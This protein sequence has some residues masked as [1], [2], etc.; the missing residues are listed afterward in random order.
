MHGLRIALIAL[1]I[2]GISW[3][4]VSEETVLSMVPRSKVDLR[5]GRD[6]ILKTMAGTKIRIE[7]KRDGKL[8]DVSGENLNKGD[9]LEPGDGLI[10]LSTAA[11][12]IGQKAEG[13]WSLELDPKL[14]WIYE[15]NHQFLV[16]AK[17]GKVLKR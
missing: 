9:E 3:G 17:S 16:D 4:V 14:G 13:N 10:S 2:P 12:A 6:F 15:V 5:Q 7:L 8:E 1:L 11:Q